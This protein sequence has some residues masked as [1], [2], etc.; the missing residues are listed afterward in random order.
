MTN[1]PELSI[2]KHSIG[3]RRLSNSTAS[4]KY[5]YWYGQRERNREIKRER[6]IQR[7]KYRERKRKE[8]EK[9]KIGTRKE[10]RDTEA[11]IKKSKKKQ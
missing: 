5:L 1:F 2:Q 4:G 11:I 10:E 9:I 6:N 3:I 7:E 8:K